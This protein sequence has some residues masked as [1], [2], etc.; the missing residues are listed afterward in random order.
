[1]LCSYCPIN[2]FSSYLH[3]IVYFAVM[4]QAFSYTAEGY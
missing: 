1:M 2:D 3:I 4:L